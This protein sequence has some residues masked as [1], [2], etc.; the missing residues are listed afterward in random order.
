MAAARLMWD[1][2]ANPDEVP[3]GDHPGLLDMDDDQS[4]NFSNASSRSNVSSRSNL[5]VRSDLSSRSRLHFGNTSDD[6]QSEAASS[7]CLG[8]SSDRQA[9]R[10]MRPPLPH[11]LSIHPEGQTPPPPPLSSQCRETSPLH[12]LGGAASPGPFGDPSS[13]SQRENSDGF[14]IGEGEG[15]TA[16]KV[17]SR[18]TSPVPSSA[19]RMMEEIA[20]MNSLEGRDES[21]VY[22]PREHTG[23]S[24]EASGSPIAAHGGP[25]TAS[26]ARFK[27][28]L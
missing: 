1:V 18:A 24:L 26:R 28:S 22:H 10:M 15:G 4:D 23:H 8:E 6:V 7:M 11:L 3:M 16:S 19:S 9:G 12:A 2:V 17:A 20:A 14:S 5:T 27:I 21:H 25:G 13:A